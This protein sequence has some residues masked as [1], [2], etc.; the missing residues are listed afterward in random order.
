MNKKHLV[1]IGIVLLLLIIFTRR[2][3]AASNARFGRSAMDVAATD[4]EIARRTSEASGWRAAMDY[5]LNR[6]TQTAGNALYAVGD[7][8]SPSA[9]APDVLPGQ[10][11]TDY[12]V[13]RSPGTYW[14]A[15]WRDVM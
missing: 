2:S 1:I 3:R 6:D 7:P 10:Q 12:T 15:A 13:D 11:G 4:K 8:N 5:M 9:V 14:R